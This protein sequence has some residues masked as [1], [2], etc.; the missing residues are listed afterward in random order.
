MATSIDPRFR[1]RV[2]AE[3]RLPDN[4]AMLWALRALL[5]V[6]GIAA[7]ALAAKL[8][9]PFWPV[10]LTM[11]TLVVLSIGAA[12]GLRLGGVTLLGYLAVGALGF[13]VFTGS[14]ATSNGLA[15]MAGGTGGYLLGFLLA[16]LALGAMA[17]AG[18]DRRPSRL[19]PALLI[20]EALIF[21][22]GVL[23][24]GYLFAADKGW[25]WVLEVGVVPFL[26][27][28]ILKVALAALL[29]PTLW[30]LVGRARG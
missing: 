27:A 28:E 22:P 1:G 11:Q 18:W 12:Y 5:V 29:L 3:T 24:L 14:S 23:W 30:R 4:P 10:P 19:V 16:T 8:K 21:V 26:P 15:Y 6:A 2:L 13:D 25:S 7:L 20:G 9:V 17:R